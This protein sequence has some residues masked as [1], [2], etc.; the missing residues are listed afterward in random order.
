MLPLTYEPWQGSTELTKFSG[1]AAAR[2]V[3]KLNGAR[4]RKCLKN[5]KCERHKSMLERNPYKV[6]EWQTPATKTK[7]QP[8]DVAAYNVTV[9]RAS[10]YYLQPPHEQS[11]TLGVPAF[12]LSKT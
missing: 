10:I 6:Y 11:L 7:D 2:L 4:D 3:A 12:P 8:L 1:R 9:P 5:G